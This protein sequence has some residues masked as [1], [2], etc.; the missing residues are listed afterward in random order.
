MEEN[1]RRELETIRGMVLNWK[2]SYLECASAPGEDDYL[3]LEFLEE[4]ETHVYPYTRRLHECQ[5]LT[6]SEVEE[7]L[8]FCYQQVA[9]LRELLLKQDTYL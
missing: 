9:E 1:V 5:Y 8:D 2:K 3:A 7:F 6:Q 4:I